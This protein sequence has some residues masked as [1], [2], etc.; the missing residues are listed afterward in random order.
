MI[1]NLHGLFGNSDNT[2]YYT[3]R[4]LVNSDE[5]LSPQLM[6]HLESPFGIVSRLQDLASE[7]KIDLIVGHSIGAF[8]AYVMSS[9]LEVPCILINPYIRPQDYLPK[10]IN[11]Y[12]EYWL[13]QL[14]MLSTFYCEIDSKHH[15]SYVGVLIGGFDQTLIANKPISSVIKTDEVIFISAGHSFNNDPKYLTEFRRMIAEHYVV[16]SSVVTSAA[17]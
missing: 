10:L 12:R 15:D 3:L 11:D 8:Y 5:I 6:Y 13:D 4:S 14:N 16:S 17:M 9:Q 2:N 1:L 7:H